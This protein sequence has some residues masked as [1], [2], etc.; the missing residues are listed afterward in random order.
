MKTQGNSCWGKVCALRVVLAVSAL[1]FAAV[2]ASAQTQGQVAE[3][4]AKFVCGTPVTTAGGPVANEQIAAGTYSTSINIHNPASDLFTSEQSVSFEKKAVIS[5]AEGTTPIAPSALVNETL[6]NDYSE[7]VDCNTIRK[8]L[9]ASAPAA[10]AFIEGWVVLLV[11][12]T[13][14]GTTNVL[15]V[16]GVYTNAK[17]AEHLVPAAE[18]FFTPGGVVAMKTANQDQKE[19]KGK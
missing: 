14:S 13:T 16:W 7:E 6:E 2:P 18:R 4:S 9:G 10:P 8:L 11:P 17:G 1:V 15:D 5:L 12:P 3:Y 19:K